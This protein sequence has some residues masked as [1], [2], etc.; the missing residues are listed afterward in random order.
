MQSSTSV[1]DPTKPKVENEDSR[2]ESRNPG[3]ESSRPSTIELRLTIPVSRLSLA[4]KITIVRILLI[5]VFVMFAIYYVKEHQEWQ[6]LSAV[7]VFFTAAVTDALD[8]YIARK[9]SQKSR[10][11]TLLDPLAD[12]LLLV[13]A[14][15]LFSID[16]GEAFERIPLWFPILVISRDLLLLGGS[17]LLQFLHGNFVAR[18]RAVGKIAT[19][20]Q[21]VTVGWVL[22]RIEPPSFHYALY[23]AGLFTFLSVIWYVYDGVRAFSGHVRPTKITRPF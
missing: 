16:N 19:V 6:W 2:D 13:S 18:P 11:G 22:L 17:M 3:I 21:M 12:K 5:P 10:L 15:V 1:P 8:G 4:N 9:Y 20:C 23:A 14:L 7:G